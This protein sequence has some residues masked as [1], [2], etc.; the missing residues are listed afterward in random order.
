MIFLCTSKMDLFTK[1]FQILLFLYEFVFEEFFFGS[2]VNDGTANKFVLN[3]LQPSFAIW[4]T[5]YTHTRLISIRNFI[6]CRGFL[7]FVLTATEPILELQLIWFSTLFL[8]L[9]FGGGGSSSVLQTHMH[10]HVYTRIHKHKKSYTKLTTTAIDEWG[11]CEHEMETKGKIRKSL[12]FIFAIN[13]SLNPTSWFAV[14]LI[15]E[16]GA[17]YEYFDP[18]FPLI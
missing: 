12:L 16:S 17:L 11:V 3:A 1:R 7:C 5:H 18:F 13:H 8:F 2:I 9:S 10:T 15:N 14:H 4:Y 6:R